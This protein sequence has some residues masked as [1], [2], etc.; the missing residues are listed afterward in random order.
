MITIV[1]IVEIIHDGDRWDFVAAN[2][3]IVK[4]V[5][6]Q[7]VGDMRAL[8]RDYMI[9][10][11]QVFVGRRRHCVRHAMTFQLGENLGEKTRLCV[12]A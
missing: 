2:A 1:D 5:V 12:D 7:V 9:V 3:Q 6:Q 11:N 10:I 8:T 4:V